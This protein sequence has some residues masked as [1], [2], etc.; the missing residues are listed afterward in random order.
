[1]SMR[2]VLWFIV[3]SR[4]GGRHK[5]AVKRASELEG[6]KRTM[7]LFA[8]PLERVGFMHACSGKGRI[9]QTDLDGRRRMRCDCE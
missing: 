9:S 3:V 7:T 8:R 4:E 5:A 1:M 6:K 2:E